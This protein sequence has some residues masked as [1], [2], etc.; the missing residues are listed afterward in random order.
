MLDEHE[1][2]EYAFLCLSMGCD[3]SE[4]LQKLSAAADMQLAIFSFDAKAKISVPEIFGVRFQTEL[5]SVDVNSPA[6]S[7]ILSMLTEAKD[8]RFSP[9]ELNKY[10]LICHPIKIG[11]DIE[12]ILI[13]RYKAENES[14]YAASLVPIISKLY[15]Y[16]YK[17]CNS[18]G[19]GDSIYRRILAKILLQ[20]NIK[21]GD[22]LSTL[23][24]IYCQKIGYLP[25]G[26]IVLDISQHGCDVRGLNQAEREL[27]SLFSNSLRV[28]TNDNL[29]AMIYSVNWLDPVRISEIRDK[30][31]CF[32]TKN[33]L[34]CGVSLPF[35]KI[36]ECFHYRLQAKTAR[37]IG[38]Y[39]MPQARCFFTADML[40]DVLLSSALMCCSP[41]ELMLAD[42]TILK[43][44]D[45]EHNTKLLS[46]L[47]TYLRLGSKSA[48]A[49]R[50]LF[51]DRS[52]L[53]YRLKKISDLIDK[54][55]D[56]PQIAKTLLLGLKIM[57]LAD[58]GVEQII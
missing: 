30:L 14:D 12:S 7:K 20:G 24:G 49:A 34:Y 58:I 48:P 50:E 36:D 27:S 23:Y 40:P 46:T 4:L 17:T 16:F 5:A 1:I 41:R 9:L 32:T 51:L 29:I 22:F 52:T 25:E 38:M 18:S 28:I 43:K 11:G 10:Y 37:S 44:H 54:D 57:H 15:A 55:I 8:V 56:D 21:S 31:E 19:H 35:H 3:F 39:A 26:Y 47:E 6:A 45:L 13:V 53:S 33:N 42:L 2:K